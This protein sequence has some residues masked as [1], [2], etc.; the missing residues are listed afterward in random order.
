MARDT[1]TP[2]DFQIKDEIVNNLNDL[3]E[4]YGYNQKDII[5]GTGLSQALISHYFKGRRM[6]TQ[7]N[8]KILANFFNVPV[9]E[10][11]PRQKPLQN[12]TVNVDKNLGFVGDVSGGTI[13]FN[14][15]KDEIEKLHDSV[16]E[17]LN[18]DSASRD[19]VNLDVHRLLLEY[20]KNMTDNT[21]DIQNELNQLRKVVESMLEKQSELIDIVKLLLEAQK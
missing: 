20:N 16:I 10:I 4:T 7:Q 5:D 19:D 3:K 14:T 11:D 1:F 6:P 12:K 13:N 8:L 18:R 21:T 15:S 2:L 9:W 17:E